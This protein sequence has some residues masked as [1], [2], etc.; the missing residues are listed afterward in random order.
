MKK[1]LSIT[2]VAAI[3][4]AGCRKIEV[5]GTTTVINTGGGTPTGQTI[6][7]E[8]KISKDTV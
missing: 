7:L 1:L 5:D 4:A 2:I 6:T 8:G 3:L